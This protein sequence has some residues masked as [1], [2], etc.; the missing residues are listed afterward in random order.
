[1]LQRGDRAVLGKDPIVV[2]GHLAG[3]Q[4]D[5]V[6]PERSG[7]HRRA[8]DLGRERLRQRGLRRGRA[9]GEK[10]KGEDEWE[11]SNTA[12]GRVV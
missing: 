8:G 4:L 5:D 2:T 12:H 6:D 11:C 10:Q 7:G 1:M 3:I 9:G